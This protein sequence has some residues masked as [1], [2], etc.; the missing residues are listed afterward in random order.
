MADLDSLIRY[1]KHIVDEKQRLLA[2]LFR[3]AE[4]LERQKQILLNQMEREKKIAEESGTLDYREYLG[5]F[6]EGVR[7]KVSALDT[8]IR[9]METRISAAQEDMR[10]AFA[11]QKKIEIVQREREIEKK[12]ALSRKETQNL[13]EIAIDTFRR[14]QE[15]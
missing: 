15:E 9:K 11:E 6:L 5:R 1:R 2:Q 13:D 12:A 4:Q 14:L 7:V 3:Q 8:S 10:S